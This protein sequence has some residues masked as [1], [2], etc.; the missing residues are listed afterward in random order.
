MKTTVHYMN[1]RKKKISNS[2]FI[3]LTA[4]LLI[5]SITIFVHNSV[6]A[7]RTKSSQ[8]AGE[9]RKSEKGLRDNRY[10]FYFINSSITNLGTEE[11]KKLYKE[12]IQR[13]ILAQL[14]YMRFM[15]LESYTEIRTAQ[16]LLINLYRKTLKRDIRATKTLLNQFAATVIETK[17]NST[18]E[19]LRLGYRDMKV[20]QIYLKM[21]DSFRKKLYSMRLYKYIHAIK[22]A[23][24]GKKYAFL[25]ILMARD[26][27]VIKK[28]AHKYDFYTLKRKVLSARKKITTLSFKKLGER[29]SEI[30]PPEK[31]TYYR[32][33]HHDNFY[34]SIDGK[35]FY[36]TIWEA[37]NLHEIKEYKKYLDD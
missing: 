18:L 19:Y 8:R 29:L 2:R 27:L 21:G 37:P 11:D 35:S 16:R 10:F 30:P 32:T 12:A 4:V 5:L 14:L 1:L 17:D 34:R 15:F 22:N 25:A 20:A 23:K 31:G 13:D 24:H 26:M 7:Q 33:I 6:Y 9:Q 28:D 3:L 36:D